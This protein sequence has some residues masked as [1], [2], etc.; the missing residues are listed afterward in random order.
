MNLGRWV[1][2]NLFINFIREEQR[3][4][5]RRVRGTDGSQR[6]GSP[7]PLPQ[8]THTH[9]HTHSHSHVHMHGTVPPSR[10]R[11]SSTSSKQSVSAP[12]P[13]PSH[14][15]VFSS[16]TLI[17]AVTPS[18]PWSPSASPLLTPKIPLYQPLSPIQQSP[19][20][21]SA[22]ANDVTPIAGHRHGH[23]KAQTDASTTPVAHAPHKE[24]HDYFTV[25]VRR[26]SVSSGG[27][28]AAAAAVA[29]VDDFSGWGGPGGKLTDAPATPTAGGLMGRLKNIG[30]ISK[31]P[32][33]EAGPATPRPT[34]SGTDQVPVAPDTTVR[35]CAAHVLVVVFFS[36]RRR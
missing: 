8:H 32:P 17:P 23:S 19:S 12:S 21:A 2:R 30:K 13:S 7:P 9:T 15:A 11:S 1:L 28:G 16:P 20:A 4:Y 34:T 33:S 31:R 6:G 29:D 22:P 10:R 18:I 14:T 27:V 25:R 5:T 36:E 24:Q 26:P 3:A 35:S